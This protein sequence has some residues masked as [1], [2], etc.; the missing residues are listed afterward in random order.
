[1]R[2][3]GMLLHPYFRCT[4]TVVGHHP[5]LLPLGIFRNHPTLPHDHRAPRH[6]WGGFSMTHAPWSMFCMTHAPWSMFCMTHALW[7]RFCMTHAPWSRFCMTHAPWSRFCMTNALWSRFCM[8]Y[9]PWPVGFVPPGLGGFS[10]T[11]PFHLGRVQVGERRQQVHV[12]ASADAARIDSC[13]G[14]RV[15]G[16]VLES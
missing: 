5:P 3:P 11:H 9:A 16:L 10:V 6:V 13:R 7:S 8:S 14:R 12:G 2:P 15:Q 1:M 4:Y